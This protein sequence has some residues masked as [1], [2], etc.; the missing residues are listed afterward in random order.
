MVVRE[1]DKPTDGDRERQLQSMTERMQTEKLLVSTTLH[2]QTGTPRLWVDGPTSDLGATINTLVRAL[3]DRGFA[4]AARASEDAGP[5]NGWPK[6]DNGL[7]ERQL[8]TDAVDLTVATARISDDQ[9]TKEG[10]AFGPRPADEAVA[11]V[12]IYGK[13]DFD[14][15]CAYIRLDRQPDPRTWPGLPTQRTS[16]RGWI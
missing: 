13:V 12:A 1:V 10:L 6:D 4:E 9:R 5:V 15:T 3:N 7:G 16:Q 14:G 8:L 2:Q 11:A